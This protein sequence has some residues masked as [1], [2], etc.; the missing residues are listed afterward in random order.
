M[1][2]EPV[3]DS[4][5]LGRVRGRATQVR[6]NRGMGTGFCVDHE[7]GLV[8]EGKEVLDVYARAPSPDH[9]SA[10]RSGPDQHP[11]HGRRRDLAP[12]VGMGSRPDRRVAEEGRREACG[13]APPACELDEA[14]FGMGGEGAGDDRP[15]EGDHGVGLA[16]R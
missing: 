11:L 1:G 6:T 16:R 4:A 14:E 7:D 12:A 13:A 3:A 15:V 8:G 10:W 9:A 5:D 2:I